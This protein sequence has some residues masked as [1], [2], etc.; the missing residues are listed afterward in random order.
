MGTQPAAQRALSAV[1]DLLPGAVPVPPGSAV[2]EY[3][4]LPLALSLPRMAAALL[5]LGLLP[6]N[7]P[8]YARG[9]VTV[10]ACL[11][12]HPIVADQVFA[13]P[14]IKNLAWYIA[15]AL[16]EALIGVV[17]GL[18]FSIPLRILEVAGNVVDFQS[19]AS[20]GAMMDPVTN[21]ETGPY[22]RLLLQI[23]IVLFLVAGG[24]LA[25]LNTVTHSYKAWP[26]MSFFPPLGPGLWTFVAD[27]LRVLFLH[28]A[29]VG[30]AVGLLL[31]LVEL[32]IGFMNRITPQLN[33]FMFSMG[34]KSVLAALTLALA[35]PVAY[36]GL[37]R[38]IAGAVYDVDNL[39]PVLTS[40]PAPR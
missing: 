26:V 10:A 27:W 6:R 34:I 14:E 15:L 16:K 17:I 30:L 2:V 25:M 29:G 39:T 1:G 9:G 12:A 8:L 28:A 19:G 37:Q 13:V 36:H 11:F 21:T 38:F 24:L 5:V 40:P 18:A 7:L 35:L 3:L 32:G 31:L 4:V 33:V 22:G 20:T 23:G